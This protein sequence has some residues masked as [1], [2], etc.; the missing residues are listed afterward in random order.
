MP[1][2]YL[3]IFVE[4][5]APKPAR[6]LARTSQTAWNPA[7][8]SLASAR[9]ALLTSAALRRPDQPSFVPPDDTSYRSLPAEPHATDLAMDHRSPLGTSPRHDP[10]IVFPRSALIALAQGNV[11]GSIART[12]F[13]FLGGTR[14]HD[15]VEKELAPA[16]V[17]ELRREEVNLALLLPF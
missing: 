15:G 2:D 14:D 4:K 5:A 11:I 16:L 3:P 17:A 9:I 7:V 6:K 13:S 10:E 8:P 12:H 1:F